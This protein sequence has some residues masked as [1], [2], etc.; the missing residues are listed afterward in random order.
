MTNAIYE[1]LIGAF[2]EHIAVLEDTLKAK[3]DLIEQLE[4]R[5]EFLNTRSIYLRRR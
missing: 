1:E 3:N 2:K 5:I 4:A